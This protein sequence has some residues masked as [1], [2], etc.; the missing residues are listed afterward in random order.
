MASAPQGTEDAARLG[1]ALRG[2]AQLRELRLFLRRA[3]LG[4][5]PQALGWAAGLLGEALRGRLPA[6]SSEGKGP[7][8]GGVDFF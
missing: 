1:E 3:G 6:F 2:L 7:Q 8:M 5:G 4:R